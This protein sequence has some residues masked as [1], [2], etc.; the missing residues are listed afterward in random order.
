MKCF[1]KTALVTALTAGWICAAS[2]ADGPR[3]TQYKSP[4]GIAFWHRARSDIP[5]ATIVAGWPDGYGMMTPGKE[6]VPQLA[7]SVLPRGAGN[8]SANELSET[9]NDLGAG[10]GMVGDDWTAQFI[11][12][13]PAGKLAAAADLAAPILTAPRLEQREIDRARRS[14]A[15]A[16]RQS[17][18]T[19]EGLATA[20]ATKLLYGDHPLTKLL[21]PAILDAVTR[22]DID[23]WRRRV[24][25]RATMV[26]AASGPL[27]P[28]D[29]GKIV[30]TLFAGLPA[31]SDM[32]TAVRPAPAVPAKTI[33]VE[34]ELAQTILLEV[35]ATGVRQDR[36]QLKASLGVDVLG[37]GFESR[38]SANVRQKLGATYGLS[39]RL[40]GMPDHKLLSIM[41]PV[42]NDRAADALAAVGAEYARWRTGGVTQD[43]FDA[44]KGR[45]LTQIDTGFARAGFD[46]GEFVGTVLGGRPPNDGADY[47]ARM[48][49]YTLE[50]INQDIAVK[51]PAPPLLTIIVGPRNDAFKADCVI[52]DWKEV[53][54]CR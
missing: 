31:T 5:S 10:G 30:D 6:A 3:F 53:M 52:K 36:D 51:F 46:A 1:S 16:L 47:A 48:A 29:F 34:K 50:T 18:A 12:S 2:A 33:L 38:I 14:I 32:P 24:L 28:E 43:E 13:A 49:S 27:S 20:V 15:D 17:A 7:R 19:G 42:A 54:T 4:A 11:L 25:A 40:I 41:G 22:E 9:M 26:V 21:D 35:A 37:G 44:A 45:T 8:R 39:A 23:L